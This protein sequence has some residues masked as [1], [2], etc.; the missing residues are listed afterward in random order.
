MS[1]TVRY[2]AD[3]AAGLKIHDIP[4]RVIEKIRLQILTGITAAALSPWHRPSQT[5]LAARK[6]NGEALVFATLDRVAPADAAF[7]NAAFAM[8]LDYDDYLLSG[9]TS[10]SAVLVPM[11]FAQTLEEVIV[12]ATAANEIMGRLSTNCFIG[13]LN[14]QMSSYIHN[15]GAAVA[16]GKTWH[17]SPQQMAHAMSIALYQP[18]YCLV[19]GFWHEATKTIT[20][21]LPIE[22]G[23]NAARLAA[24]GLSGPPDILDH[25]LGFTHAFS[26]SDYKGLYQGL[27]SVWFS[28][29]LSYKR[30]PGTSYIS[31]AVEGALAAG[32]EN[33][34]QPEDI[35]SVR[36]ETTFLSATLDQLGAAAIDRSPLDANAVNF[37]LRLSV[38]AALCFGDLT[39][40][41][42]RPE[43][44]A[45]NE[46]A[47]RALSARIK[48]VHDWR[49]SIRMVSDSPVGIAMFAQLKPKQWLRVIRHS[50]DFNR[51]SEKAS[52][53]ASIYK[54]MWKDA[55]KLAGQFRK[56]RK[57]PITALDVDT[58]GFR[59]RQSA[60]VVLTAGGNTVTRMVEIPVG[61]CGRDFSETRGLVRWRCDKA[62]G[63]KG[64]KV[65]ETVFQDGATVKS[66]YDAVA[67]QR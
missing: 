21:S 52:R 49:Q 58:V 33:P 63:E 46:A 16:L 47:I 14:G 20:A 53:K 8:A 11:A 67:G 4:A 12:A 15:I 62:F 51:S 34:L 43:T 48:V 13:P 6:S 56:G 37:S 50:R 39:P 29:T 60:R 19:P 26:F 30:Y 28:D 9:H 61:A 41:E 54:G 40:E 32:Q 55:L 17:L 7:I 10:H 35:Q 18:N 44:L 64:K 23:L 31:A 5:V 57:T 66:L 1:S 65:W 38:A 45:S 3:W 22:Q 24:A 2:M 25:D 42:L 59:M 36:V 27:G